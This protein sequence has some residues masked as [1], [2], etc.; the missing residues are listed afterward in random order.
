VNSIRDSQGSEFLKP[1]SGH[2]YKMADCTIENLSDE[3][4]KLSLEYALLCC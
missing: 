2:I 1:E 3:S 4:K